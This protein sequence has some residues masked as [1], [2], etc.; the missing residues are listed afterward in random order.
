MRS[1]PIYF[2]HPRPWPIYLNVIRVLCV[3]G[4]SSSSCVDVCQSLHYR[5]T[6]LQLL[7]VVLLAVNVILSEKAGLRKSIA[8]RYTA[9]V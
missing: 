2:A 9:W 8:N 6:F 5:V 4:M 7:N 1:P 3:L